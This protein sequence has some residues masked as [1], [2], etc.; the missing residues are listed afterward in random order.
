LTLGELGC[1]AVVTRDARY[2]NNVTIW[3][4]TGKK[5]DNT[6]RKA[7]VRNDGKG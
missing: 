2:F 3:I 5:Q 4:L 1:S 6:R 7:G